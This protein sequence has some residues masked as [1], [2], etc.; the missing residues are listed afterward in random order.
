MRTPRPAKRR[1]SVSRTILKDKTVT[2]SLI[3][4]FSCHVKTGPHL[5][6]ITAFQDLL[7]SIGFT[8]VYS[9]RS[10]ISYSA[11]LSFNVNIGSKTYSLTTI[12]RNNYMTVEEFTELHK[13]RI[14]GAKFGL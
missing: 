12:P 11:A 13:G 6:H 7:K 9:N 10:N 14:I 3:R 8:H 4:K 1:L 2:E 5:N